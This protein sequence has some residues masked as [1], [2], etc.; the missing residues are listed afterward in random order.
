MKPLTLLLATS[1]AANAAFFAT[2]GYRPAVPTSPSATGPGPIAPHAAAPTPT[3]AAPSVPANLFEALKANKTDSIR[4]FLR[5]AGLPEATIRSLVASLIWDRF[6][7]QA[8]AVY[9]SRPDQPWWKAGLDNDQDPAARRERFTESRRLFREAQD[10]T[11][12][13]FGPDAETPFSMLRNNPHLGFLSETKRKNVQ[14]IEQDYEDLTQAVQI[15]MVGFKLPADEEKLK[16]IADEKRRDLAAL[17]TPQELAD[18][19]LRTSPTA[20]QLRRKVTQ[21]D[22]SEEE[23]RK[24]FAIQKAYDDSHALD[25]GSRADREK[26]QEDEKQLRE[27]FKTAL[28][29]Q[30]YADYQLSQNY[31]YQKLVAATQ[32]L[33]LPVETARQVFDLRTTVSSE[34]VCIMDSPDLA[35]AQKKQALAD[36]AQRTR[37][38]IVS[39]LGEAVTDVYIKNNAGWLE[40]VG[41]GHAFTIDAENNSVNFRRP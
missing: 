24:L 30:R 38:Q 22:G 8:K 36:L 3:T 16:F 32:R 15:N 21:F 25:A 20:E 26:R 12:R 10:T 4:D 13:V 1:L 19:D 11:T 41:E 18:Y 40:S 7:L 2:K 14:E 39:R 6:F 23:Y 35:A 9:G 29:P 5:A 37:A 33:A 28:G 31:E 34:S 17:L 27:Q